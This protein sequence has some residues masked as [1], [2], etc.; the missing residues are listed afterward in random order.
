MEPGDTITSVAALE[1]LYGTARP[2]SLAKEMAVIDDAYRRLIEAAPFCA[3]ATVGPGGLDCSPR[4]DGPGFVRILDERTVAIPDRRGNR[5]L[6]TLRN[7]VADPRVALLFLIPGWEEAL[8]INGRAT[9]NTNAE[10]LAS[11]A[12]DGKEPQTAVIVEIDTMYFQCARAIKR[13]GLW[14]EKAKVDPAS[15]PS[16]G[17]LLR[18]AVKDF[19]GAAYDVELQKRQAETLY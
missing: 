1:A 17:D 4:G 14:D 16:A 7:I 5:R 9:I 18:S 11:M 8:R 3:V 10:L 15:L 12:V 6:D 2:T 13:A 19:D